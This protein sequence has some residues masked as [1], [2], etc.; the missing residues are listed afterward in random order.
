MSACPTKDE[1][2]SSWVWL[3]CELRSSNLWCSCSCC[4]CFCLLFDY[5]LWVGVDGLFLLD[6]LRVS[7]LRLGMMCLQDDERK[8]KKREEKSKGEIKTRRLPLLF[9]FLLSLFD[10]QFDLPGSHVLKNLVPCLPMEPRLSFILVATFH[11]LFS[12][13]KQK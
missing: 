9:L 12:P 3:W 10:P 5:S 2:E 13:L 4:I 7:C 1:D 11:L 8:K 6:V